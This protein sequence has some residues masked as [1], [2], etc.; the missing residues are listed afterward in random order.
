VHACQSRFAGDASRIRL[1][2][3]L[4]EAEATTTTADVAF[5][6]A[7]SLRLLCADVCDAA[8]RR[9]ELIAAHVPARH[10]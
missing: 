1:D 10:P 8:K 9:S 5:I 6:V 2:Y 4:F 3:A 7:T